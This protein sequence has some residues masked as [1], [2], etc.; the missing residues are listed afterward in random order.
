[1]NILCNSVCVMHCL[2]LQ[3]F[4]LFVVVLYVIIEP[5]APKERKNKRI[6]MIIVFTSIGVVFLIIVTALLSGFL[7]FYLKFKRK[8]AHLRE[9]PNIYFNVGEF[10]IKY[11][12]PRDSAAFS[13]NITVHAC[14]KYSR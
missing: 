14:F 12:C 9:V 7:C 3:K 10:F 5:E 1:M 11:E 8:I 13:F 6:R 4:S 2:L